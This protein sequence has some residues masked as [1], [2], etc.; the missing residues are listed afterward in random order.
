M[1]A[2]I[3]AMTGTSPSLPSPV[4]PGVMNSR[5]RRR[6]RRWAGPS[7]VHPAGQSMSLHRLRHQPR[8]SQGSPCR[9]SRPLL[10][11]STSCPPTPSLCSLLRR[12]LRP[13]R[14]ERK[15]HQSSTTMQVSRSLARSHAVWGLAAGQS[16]PS[17]PGPPPALLTPILSPH[18]LVGSCLRLLRQA[19]SYGVATRLPSLWSHSWGGVVPENTHVLPDAMA[20]PPAPTSTTYNMLE[21]AAFMHPSGAWPASFSSSDQRRDTSVRSRRHHKV[22]LALSSLVS[23]FWAAPTSLFAA[24]LGFL[25]SISWG[26]VTHCQWR[27]CSSLSSSWRRSLCWASS[28]MGLLGRRRRLP[29]LS[30]RLWKVPAWDTWLTLSARGVTVHCELDGRESLH[31]QASIF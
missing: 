21:D 5:P 29:V 15:M 7:R 20:F 24:L 10:G 14:A 30:P 3:G 12:T 28:R 8:L 13:W 16:R 11:P 22:C 17:M 18:L 25:S 9:I 2:G 6:S 23:T 1:A 19:R 4:P 31:G 26:G 27:C